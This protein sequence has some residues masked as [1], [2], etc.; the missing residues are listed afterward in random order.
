MGFFDFVN[1]KNILTGAGGILLGPLGAAGGRA[2]GGAIFGDNWQP[3]RQE[4]EGP[5]TAGSFLG[6]AALGGAAG[7]AGQAASKGIGS[8]IGEKATGAAAALPESGAGSAL[9][10]GGGSAI[11]GVSSSLQGAGE[12]MLMEGA[13]QLPTEIAGASGGGGVGSAIASAASGGGAGAGTAGGLGTLE[14]AALAGQGA[15][16]LGSMYGSYKQGEIADREFQLQQEERE[17]RRRLARELQP[18]LS[19]L[20]SQMGREIEA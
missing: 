11:P 16:A 8:L 3:G 1:P 17:R 20:I 2:L 10:G 19:K 15:Q 12:S 7:L 4:G 18:L 5:V 9:T 6:D 13:G 14:T